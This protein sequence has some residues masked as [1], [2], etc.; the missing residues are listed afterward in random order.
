MNRNLA[1][2]SDHHRRI[3]AVL[4][5]DKG[6]NP[7]LVGESSQAVLTGFLNS[8]DNR[9]DGLTAVSLS[10]EIFDQINVKFDKTYLDARFRELEKVAEQGSRPGLVLSYGDLRVFTDGEGSAASYIVSRVSELLRRLGR[11]VWLIGATTSNE[12]Y[13]KMVKKFP[14]VEKD[15]DMQLLTITTTT[16]GSCLPHHKSRS[17]LLSLFLP[18]V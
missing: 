4:A 9:T 14:N 16:L 2:D 10:S 6:R 11:R 13:E 5:R 18:R 8:L 7:L 12:V 17:L 1:G 3:S 15:W